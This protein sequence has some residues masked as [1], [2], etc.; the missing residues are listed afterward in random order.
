MLL[1]VVNKYDG[2][3]RSGPAETRD[4]ALEKGRGELRTE[5]EIQGVPLLVQLDLQKIFEEAR[6]R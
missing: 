4:F 3:G 5:R 1:G 2:A 6:V